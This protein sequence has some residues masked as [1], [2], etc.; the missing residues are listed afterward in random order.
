MNFFFKHGKK[1][2]KNF[3]KK[4]EK[5]FWKKMEKNF[6][7]KNRKKWKKFFWKKNGKFFFGKKQKKCTQG[8]WSFKQS[9]EKNH[10]YFLCFVC[11]TQNK[12]VDMMKLFSN[13]SFYQRIYDVT[14]L[15]IYTISTIIG[16]E[17][18]HFIL[19]W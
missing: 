1:M 5:I 4:W 9:R 2:K 3:G 15:I 8:I 18:F 14:S 17:K 6:L 11:A 12:A 7:E 13:F 19:V 16:R 10:F